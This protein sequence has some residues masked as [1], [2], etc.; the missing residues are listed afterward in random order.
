ML[1]NDRNN[2]RKGKNK[3]RETVYVLFETDLY[4]SLK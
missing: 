4:F 2:E 1:Y 3:D